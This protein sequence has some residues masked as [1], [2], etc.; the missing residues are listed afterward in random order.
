MKTVHLD[1]AELALLRGAV[2]SYVTTF[3]HDEHEVR[4]R[5]KV[6]LHKL[7]AAPDDEVTEARE[8]IG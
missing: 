2:H 4:E 3:G 8:L 1:S 5:A 6:L 7:D